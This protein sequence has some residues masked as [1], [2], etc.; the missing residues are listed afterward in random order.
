MTDLQLLPFQRRWIKAALRPG[1]RT[2]ALSLP[3][4]NGKSTLAAHLASRVLTPGDPMFRKGTESLIVA[5]SLAQ[6]RRTVFAQLRQMLPTEGY[7]LASSHA[8]CHA[9]HRETGTQ[10]S[11]L[12]AN[13][14]TAQGLVNVPWLFCDEPGA[15]ETNA[16]TAMYDA[17]QT[18]HGK[19]GSAMKV[20]YFGTQSPATDGWWI[21]L[22]D[23]GSTPDQH[24]LRL[25]GDPK[26]WA[27]LRHVRAMNPLV[28]K[29]PES[30]K[31]LRSELAKARRD[32]RLK[33][34][35]LSYRMNCPSADES[36]MLLAVDDWKAVCSRP[37]PPR[38][39]RPVVG[40][41]LG[42][43]ISWCGAAGVWPN[44]RVEAVAVTPGIPTLR[45][46]EQRDR[47]PKGTY[48]RLVESGRLHV[49]VGLRV[50][51]P[52]QLMG[53]VRQWNPALI[54]SDRFRY[55]ELLDANP[56]CLVQGRVTR[57]SEASSDIRG[58]RRLA[59][60]DGLAVERTSRPLLKHSIS[61]AVVESDSDGNQRLVKS[62]PRKRTARDDVAA[63]LLLAGGA[64]ARAAA[65]R[66]PNYAV[67]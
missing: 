27:D 14:K 13:P 28:Y 10:L 17:I 33:A 21:D 30:R 51:R 48:H 34:R 67:A 60:D 32:T 55:A 6:G 62:K 44:G 8:Y 42:G 26:R 46:Q 24:V 49:A 50:P 25:Q 31:V 23:E 43:G 56:P 5:A 52:A 38:W 12:P 19:P 65:P 54:V 45:E 58:L 64:M 47:V 57:W 11:V 18:A 29:F 41:D 37:V 2:A 3:R 16:G 35:F 61:Q 20:M 7:R 63:A 1:I 15:W 40:V 22:L 66:E 9:L 4:G 59:K 53:L 36:A 39:Q